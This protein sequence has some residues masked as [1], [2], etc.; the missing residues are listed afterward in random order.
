[1]GVSKPI[2]ARA[3]MAQ[4]TP[5]QRVRAKATLKQSKEISAKQARM[6]SQSKPAPKEKAAPA[7]KPSRLGGIE[8]ARIEKAWKGN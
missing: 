3:A 2:S 8:G 1:M 7:S 4:L 6:K 5:A